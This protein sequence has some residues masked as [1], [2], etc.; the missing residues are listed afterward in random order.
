[1]AD[2]QREN[3]CVLR[4]LRLSKRGQV[5]G[6]QEHVCWDGSSIL[7]VEGKIQRPL[8]EWAEGGWKVEVLHKEPAAADRISVRTA[9]IKDGSLDT[10]APRV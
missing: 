7:S 2:D 8:S 6:A 3:L 1:M 10:A 4:T 9:K 5:H